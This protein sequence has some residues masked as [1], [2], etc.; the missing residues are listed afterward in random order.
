MTT[1]SQKR[2]GSAAELEVAYRL[3]GERAYGYGPIDVRTP[4]FNIQ[5]KATSIP[6]S[7]NAAR[8]CF[9]LIPYRDDRLRGFVQVSRPGR[10]RPTRR[11][12]VFD[13][14][15]FSEWYGRG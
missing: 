10:G 15:E 2:I 11:T 6:L 12:I 3:G 8:A 5:V 7:L 9:E 4:A 1:S 13:L 14:D